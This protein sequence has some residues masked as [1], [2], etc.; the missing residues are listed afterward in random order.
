[1]NAGTASHVGAGDNL[2]GPVRVGEVVADK[3]LIVRAL[4][5]GGMGVVVEA[6][7]QLLDRRVAM[8][9]LLP[10]LAGSETAVQRFLREARAATRVTSEHVVRLLEI[11][12]L[13]SGT[14]FFV[15]EYLQGCDLRSL[16]RDRGSLSPSQ[17]VD[18]ILQAIQAVAEGH[19]RGVIHRDIKPG[20]LFLTHRADGTPLIKV[21]DFGIAK[22]LES[23]AA[24]STSLTSSEDVRLGSPAYMPPEQLHNPRDVDT[25]SDIWSLGATLYE[26]LCGR[27]PFEGTSYLELASNVLSLPPKPLS[28]Q[29]P[30]LKLPDG[31][32]SVVRRCL[33]KDREA[34]YPNA[35]ELAQALAPF[36]SADALV[37]LTRVSGMFA[38][39][40]SFPALTRAVAQ[41]A[42]DCAP[43]LDVAGERPDRRS[44]DPG[45]V[46]TPLPPPPRRSW[47][48]VA[49]AALVIAGVVALRLKPSPS[50]PNTAAARLAP[51]PAALD[52]PAA[53]PLALAEAVE[54]PKAEPAAAASAADAPVSTQTARK[55]G[56]RA[57]APIPPEK[58]PVAAA[59]LAAPTTAP[60]APETATTPSASSSAVP[61]LPG[62]GRSLEIERL[63]EQRR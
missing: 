25:R 48:V 4:G 39:S 50:T 62:S 55:S 49:A 56:A 7:D 18:Y 47:L 57:A 16:L 60:A 1:M 32:E 54:R 21:L 19:V 13:P 59:T 24:E 3:Y 14:P 61:T 2:I 22:T 35:A 9:F 28:A 46:A 34:R 31:L 6:R 33:E 11:E 40:S 63:I 15:M 38:S 8:K 52:T 44:S 17:A 23:D 51:P 45:P 29:H 36:G 12:K 5:V 30:G 43:T 27:P 10:K 41:D 26:L 42:N 53:E 20:N 37:S 58:T